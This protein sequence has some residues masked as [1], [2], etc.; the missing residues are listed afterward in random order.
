MLISSYYDKK[1]ICGPYVATFLKWTPIF[2]WCMAMFVVQL[3]TK[4]LNF[5]ACAQK[6]DTTLGSIVVTTGKPI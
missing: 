3:G 1:Q 6:L 5:E 2:E 4:T